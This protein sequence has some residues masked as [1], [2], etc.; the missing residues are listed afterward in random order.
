MQDFW[1]DIR[2]A[3]RTLRK[4]PGFTI[5]AI[6]TLGLG[7]AV[8]TT[9]FS[10]VNGLIL[11]PL[12]VPHAE[13]ITVL[14]SQQNGASTF[15]MFSYLDYQDVA[16]DT[17][18]IFSDVF[19]YRTTLGGLN[20]DGRG[21][22]CIFSRV[23]GNY[24]SALGVKPALGRLIMSSEGKTPGADSVVVLGYNYWQKRFGGDPSV[25]GK[26]V[27]IDGQ[28]A[29][30][31][32]VAEKG[33]Q[34]VYSVIDMD[35]YLPITAP[36]DAL[37]DPQKTLH[38]EFAQR[39][40]RSLLLLARLKQG[41]S[42]DQARAALNVEAR[43]LAEND[44]SA[45]K[46]M[47]IQIY[48]EKM[49]RPEPD[50][51]ATVP[52]AAI[53]FSILAAL[54]LLVACFNI[55]NV[56]L[57][58]AT[59]RE[60]EMGVRAALGAGRGRLVRQHLTESL[61]L[62][63]L[64]AIAG[65]ILAAWSAGFLSSLPLGTDLPIRFDFYP[66]VRVYLFALAVVF[67]VAVVVGLVPALRVARSDVNSLLREGGRSASE[68]RKRHIVRNT[69]V[70]A[71]LAGSM[72]L[73]IVA[74][75]FM[76]SLTKAENIDLG[77][78]PDHILNLSVDV[79][80]LNY[81]EA[82]GRA[83]FQQVDDRIAALPGV[84]SEAQAFTV[85]LGLISSEAPVT[86]P[87]RTL[88]AGE[89][90]PHI[91]KNQVTPKYFQTM[92]IPLQAGRAFT[93]ADDEKAPRVAVVNE[94]MARQF[95]PGASAIGEHF[96]DGDAA[97]K[98]IEVVGVAKD[99]SYKEISEEHKTPFFYTPAAQDY[100]P[101]RTIHVR[102]SVPPESLALTIESQIRELAPGLA[103]SQV[104]TMSHS[105]QG[106][107]GFFFFRFGAQLTGAMG[108]LGLILA[109]VGVFSMVSY[110]AAQRTHEIG[111]RMALGAAP[112]D[113][114]RMVLR[115]SA[116]V[117]GIGLAVGL[118]LALVGTRA[119]AN[120]IIGVTSTDPAT[121]LTVATL[122]SSVAALACWIPARRATKAS[123]LVALRHE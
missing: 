30:I 6:V 16:R 29:T 46:G 43:R 67:L 70:A 116:L 93:A 23:T 10:V 55:A 84:V 99:G 32:G 89:Q 61:M 59:A 24:F 75:L 107:N 123:P 1:Q 117:V 104:E 121:F 3:A 44:P 88:P 78:N 20:A 42:M 76:R 25:I 15:Q 87:G 4:S 14:S 54:V 34:G 51:D 102:T 100:V 53:A 56:M 111:I 119:L 92:Q 90:P 95:W 97:R 57:V 81:S 35:G 85:P 101:M 21:E 120:F 33:F 5:I 40:N 66:D 105:L 103:V 110:A 17:T 91:M 31:V 13:Q 94:T 36:F 19:G 106:V 68:G 69:L 8:N 9:V 112:R 18:G 115:Q 11:R 96:S 28:S 41:V 73:L 45:D 22:H 108:V 62:S 65:F 122:L 58:R 47:S 80:Q 114:L 74:G 49:A 7:M 82:R 98:E 37:N 77:F 72:L 48:P 27:T 39:E 52:R 83:F 64:G 50:P 38:D 63:F 113:I 60:R 12:P 26:Q 86:I 2:Y 118:A 109:V 79:N 71:Q